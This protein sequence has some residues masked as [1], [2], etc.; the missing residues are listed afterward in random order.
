MSTR[1]GP[2]VSRGKQRLLTEYRNSIENFG[3][4]NSLDYERVPRFVSPRTRSDWQFPAFVPQEPII[5]RN[6][7]SPIVVPNC[8]PRFHAMG[9]WYVKFSRVTTSARGGES[10]ETPSRIA[11]ATL[12]SLANAFEN[13]TNWPSRIFAMQMGNIEISATFVRCWRNDPLCKVSRLRVPW[14]FPVIPIIV[15]PTTSFERHHETNREMNDQM[16][17]REILPLY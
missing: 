8:I 2:K 15:V 4:A 3:A 11:P 1:G 17:N 9:Q 5:I 10:G 13:V 7:I 12:E 16:V 6:A 14:I